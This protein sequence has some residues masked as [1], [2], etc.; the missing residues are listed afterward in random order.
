MLQLKFENTNSWTYKNSPSY[1][2]LSLVSISIYQQLWEIKLSFQVAALPQ[3]VAES[4]LRG[5]AIF[6]F[7]FL[8]DPLALPCKSSAD[9][10]QANNIQAFYRQY[11]KAE[12]Y[13]VARDV[14]RPFRKSHGE[15][16]V[17]YIVCWR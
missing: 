4:L 16:A 15:V 6:G 14:D 8:G 11:P 13:V 5:R 2:G 10:F 17:T 7:L 1:E 12:Y 3:Q 9:D